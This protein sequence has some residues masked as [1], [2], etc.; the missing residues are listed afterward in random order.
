MI[1]I[2]IALLALP[3]LA[4]AQVKIP[5][6][7]PGTSLVGS[8]PIPTVQSNVTVAT[9]P[10]DIAAYV[11]T[12]VGTT[13]TFTVSYTTGFAGIPTQDFQWYK[14]GNIVVLK[15][16]TTVTGTSQSNGLATGSGALPP[17]LRP[18]G[19]F[20][21][22]T[23]AG[24]GIDN[25]V[26]TLLCMNISSNGTIR[27]GIPNGTDCGESGFTT[28]GTKG[29]RAAGDGSLNGGVMFYTYAVP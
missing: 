28:S 8:E 10:A 9:T 7:P 23:F 15:P 11:G 27:W 24:G 14:T 25:G 1:R 13:G 22:I 21:T 18:A 5:D 19:N 20:L 6:L 26:D 29:V 3:V 12:T 17:Q 2:F 16:I 4:F